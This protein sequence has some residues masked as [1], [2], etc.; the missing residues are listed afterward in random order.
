MLIHLSK[1]VTTADMFLCWKTDLLYII[2]D[3]MHD[4][5]R[6]MFK[7]MVKG[8]KF[9]MSCCKTYNIRN[10]MLKNVSSHNLNIALK[11]RSSQ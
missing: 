4:F 7:T 11:I 6:C 1:S 2:K 5:V 9:Q 3:I 8:L 10:I